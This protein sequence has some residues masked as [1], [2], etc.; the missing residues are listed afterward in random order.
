MVLLT[1]FTKDII[2]KPLILNNFTLNV[3]S[4]LPGEGK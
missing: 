3:H 2:I 4:D 1:V